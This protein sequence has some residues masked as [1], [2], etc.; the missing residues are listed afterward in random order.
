MRAAE[1]PLSGQIMAMSL[2]II[3]AWMPLIT[4]MKPQISA[5]VGLLMVLRLA[6]LY[7]PQLAPGRWFLFP[8]T[9][10]GMA[11]VFSAYHTFAG[12]N[13][14]TA[15]L[16]TMLVLKLLEMHRLRDIRIACILFGFLLVS[17][18][19]FDQSPWRTLYLSTLLVLDFALMADLTARVRKG[20]DAL[21]S[22]LRIA[23][24]LT[25]QA[26][27][28]TLVLFVLF[29]RLSAPLWNLN[30]LD[31]KAR[32]GVKDWLEPG[33]V[34]ELV[35]SG[36]PAFRVR[37]DGPVPPETR[38]YWRG[39]VVWYTDGRRWTGWPAEVPRGQAVALQKTGEEV[40]YRV[41]LEPGS[42]RWL[43]ALDLPVYVPANAR[44]LADFQVLASQQEKSGT[45]Y[46]LI[47]ALRYDTGELDPNEESLGTKLPDNVTPRMHALVDGWRQGAAN[48]GDVVRRALDFFREEPF[49]YTLL[50]PKLGANPADEFLFET[51][52]G[53]C[54]HYASSFAL[55]MRVAG[56]PARIVLGYL[57]GEYNGL[58]DYLLV[59]Q[60]DAHAWVEVWLE[61]K[62]WT[63][64]D[65]TAAIAPGRVQHNDLL[66]GLAGGAPV[67]FRLDDVGLLRRW[68]HNLRLLGDAMGTGWREW[69]LGLSSAHQ[70]RLLDRVGLGFLREYG[71]A[72]ALVIA[73]VVVLG[74][75]LAALTRA[76]GRRD[77]LERIYATFCKRLSHA[78][79]P[80]QPSEGP[81]DFARRVVAARP[82]LRAPVESF[83][84][85]Y[86]P[87]R[88]GTG[89]RPEVRRE[90]ERRLRRFRPRRSP[91]SRRISSS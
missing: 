3:L 39:P 83:I 78:G 22:A 61:G 16:A 63:R 12:Q 48:P 77:Q 73:A 57:G 1:Y 26:L 23:A 45:S 88:Y 59:R 8:L 13:G 82:D 91:H 74:L 76:T 52:R 21:T 43:F 53:F 6:S 29:P 80:R 66:D 40:A 5:Y 60:S 56:I 25:V 90:L 49:H 47:S 35:I 34:S 24:R 89:D 14:G 85:S 64:V 18:F 46:R 68:A 50:P 79:L 9:I 33:S 11:N 71:L 32:S 37:F 7:W 30:P 44:L 58:G 15:L 84:A 55:L 36:E 67:R 87:Q 17:Q 41:E 38:R 20:P 2:L 27:P 28:L 62:G 65:P 75:L 69:V 10:G 51:R 86:L 42:K 72:L 70:L 31:E 81:L 4:V 19:L 54:E